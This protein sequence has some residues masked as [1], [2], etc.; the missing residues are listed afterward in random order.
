MYVLRARETDTNSP[1]GLCSPT[2]VSHSVMS[3]VVLGDDHVEHES[4][5]IDTPFRGERRRFLAGDFSVMTQPFPLQPRDLS[6]VPCHVP[7]RESDTISRSVCAPRK[8]RGAPSV[9]CGSCWSTRL[10]PTH[11]FAPGT[12]DLDSRLT[13]SR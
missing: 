6:T 3:V 2:S 11:R 13:A 1:V 5:A 10:R 12:V 4:S 9:R 8:R 7:R